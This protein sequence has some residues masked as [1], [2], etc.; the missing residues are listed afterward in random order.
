MTTQKCF[1]L[2]FQKNSLGSFFLF[3]TWHQLRALVDSNSSTHFHDF[4]GSFAFQDVSERHGDLTL[5]RWSCVGRHPGTK[6]SKGWIVVRG[7]IRM[8]KKQ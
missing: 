7:T 4:P 5:L 1:F 3:H 8:D 2:I 6:G